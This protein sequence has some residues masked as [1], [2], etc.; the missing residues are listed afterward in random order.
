MKK[1]FKSALLASAMMLSCAPWGYAQWSTDL[2]QSMLISTPDA[3][4]Q[5]YPLCELA[6]DGKFWVAWVSWD[7]DLQNEV[8]GHPKI[9]LLDDD[10]TPLLGEGGI[11]VSQAPT[12]TWM[13]GYDLKTTLD[14][15]AVLVFIDKRHGMLHPFVYRI[16]T[17]GEVMWGGPTALL[18]QT[19]NESAFNAR[20]CVT[21]KGN[22]YAAYWGLDGANKA[23][24]IFKLSSDGKM[25]WGGNLQ[26][27]TGTGNYSIT[28]NGDDGFM[29]SYYTD[30]GCYG[31]MRYT[32]SGESAWDSPKLIDAS[33]TVSLTA[34]PIVV[35]DGKGG[36]YASWRNNLTQY[37]NA[38]LVQH[39]NADGSMAWVD[40]YVV[41]NL[42]EILPDGEDG[43]YA[44]WRCGGADASTIMLARIDANG[45]T[46]W[47]TDVMD[48]LTSMVAVYGI[49]PRPD[50]SVMAIYRNSSAVKSATIQYCIYSKDGVAQARNMYASSMSGDKGHG[51][52]ATSSN[53]TL[54]VWGDNDLANATGGR[55][56]GHKIGFDYTGI[57]KVVVDKDDDSYTV[58][59]MAGIQVAQGRGSD[60]YDN[61][62]AGLYIVK[63]AG[64]VSKINI[65]K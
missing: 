58:Y 17:N 48:D 52:I 4:G 30:S 38:S 13:S 57:D 55:V 19:S 44:A 29:L 63:S 7:K 9:Q 18:P 22:I 12:S 26:L 41:D 40:P 8:N 6:P 64:K 56:Y 31:V 2:S 5:D 65:V 3:P 42:A 46:K 11:Y 20:L 32:S 25:A 62:P 39:V 51:D 24:K 49:A 35:A 34:E 43:C 16:N 53:G 33:G 54:V 14:G 37:S 10:G 15:D 28:P 45:N 59:N 60:A 23:I 21:S 27:P 61:I 50:G 47:E 1:P 36:F